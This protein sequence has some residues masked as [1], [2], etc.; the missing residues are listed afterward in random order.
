MFAKLLK[1]EFRA[2]RGIIGLLCAIILGSGVVVGAVVR[3]MI[4]MD[5]HTV[6]TASDEP[7]VVMILCTLVL[8]AAILAIAV[9]G[10]GSVFF[11]IFR[12][13]KSRFTDEGYLTFTLPVS[14]HQ[15]L[16]SS[17]ANTIIGTVLVVLTAFV[18]IGIAVLLFLSAFPQEYLWADVEY[19]VSVGLKDM[20]MM[21]W[22]QLKEAFAE[23]GM[24]IGL[25]LFSAV[26]SAVSELVTLMLSVTIGALIAKKHKILAAIAVY[27]GINMVMSFVHAM[28]SLTFAAVQNVTWF[29]AFPGFMALV[30]AVAGYFLMYY[31]TSRK[32]NL[33]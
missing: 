31:L 15:L 22:P 17:I 3:Y 26:S 23:Y 13:Y 28:I 16:L 20:W 24:E 1:H 21:L 25:A 27:Y 12:F 6:M 4:W 10:S 14:H 30:L 29:V 32:L 33:A 2:T 11:L 19:T 7:G 9:C 8:L 18:A 5:D